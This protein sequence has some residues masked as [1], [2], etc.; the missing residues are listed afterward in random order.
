MPARMTAVSESDSRMN[1]VIVYS[2]HRGSRFCALR[3]SC[4]VLWERGGGASGDENVK[5]VS[6][7]WMS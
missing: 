3:A 5:C 2:R 6:L 7:L 1:G 4:G